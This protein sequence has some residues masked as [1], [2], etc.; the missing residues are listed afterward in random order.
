M[1]LVTTTRRGGPQPFIFVADTTVFGFGSV[2]GDRVPT[3]EYERRTAEWRDPSARTV[4]AKVVI[5]PPPVSPN[6][7][8]GN[9]QG[10]S[11]AA[12]ASR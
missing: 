8:V 4:A 5:D 9:K 1:L 3:L 11:T 12:G 10:G 6:Q 2:Q 7:E